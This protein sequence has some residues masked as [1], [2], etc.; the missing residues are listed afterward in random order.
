M[1]EW[2]IKI[3]RKMLNWEWYNDIPTK[4]LFIH[5]LLKANWEDKKRHWIEIKRWQY[6]TSV[7]K[8]ATETKLTIKQIRASID[9]LKRTGEVANETTNNYSLIKL[10]NYDTYQT[11]G[12][13]EWQTKGKLR[14]T[15]KELKELKEE[16]NDDFEKFWNLYPNKKWKDKARKIFNNSTKDIDIEL[17]LLCVNKYK[18][19]TD[20]L[21]YKHW[22]TFLNQ[23]TWLDYDLEKAKKI[24]D[25]MTNER[26]QTLFYNK[27]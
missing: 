8:L 17:L 21:Y 12:Q 7:S 16:Y 14:A 15:T 20:P 2:F 18:K 5:L 6:L 26:K 10:L 24:L 11:V 13:T 3:Y 23:K 4:V 1:D 19:E 25:W 22:D 9:K 27:I